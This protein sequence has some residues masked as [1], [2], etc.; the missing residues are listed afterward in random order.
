MKTIIITASDEKYADITRG[1]LRSLHQWGDLPC[2]EIGLL[3]VGLSEKTREEFARYASVIVEPG[4][5]FE[6][7]PAMR[8]EQPYL[9]AKL[10]RPRLPAYF[11]G[12]DLYLWLDADIWVQNRFAIEW[13][14]EAARTGGMA[15]VPSSDRSYAFHPT[16]IEWRWNH[17]HAYFGD[18]A[19]Q[20]YHFK[21]Y[22]NS[23]AFALVR[24]AP[25]WDVWAK[26]F[27][28]ALEADPAR[29]SDQAVMNY[30]IW[31][32]DLPVHPLPSR[33]N[34]LCH[35]RTPAFDVATNQFCEP[36]AP[37]LPLGMLHLAG[38]S[39]NAM[40]QANR[41]G[42]DFQFSLQYGALQAALAQLATGQPAT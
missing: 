34:W 10:A 40:V 35:F 30:A 14:F 19:M 4:W 22:Y 29:V 20:L 32:D 41:G 11:P 28:S 6:I 39:K 9:R 27:E 3:D 33:C 1:L 16:H 13:F 5:D 26:W 7:D 42:Q 18:E 31:K 17:L 8:Q 12:R 2:G 24:D 21:Q 15:V 38:R 37:H 25:H 36:F 23:G